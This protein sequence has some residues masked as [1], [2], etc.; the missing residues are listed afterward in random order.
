VLFLIG[1]APSAEARTYKKT[2]A[3]VRQSV[4]LNDR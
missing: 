3:Q 2:F 1:V 4:Q